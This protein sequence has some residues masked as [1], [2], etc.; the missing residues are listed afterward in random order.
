MR[1]A[2]SL[3]HHAM[4]RPFLIFKVLLTMSV[5]TLALSGCSN[6]LNKYFPEKDL[7]E[8]EGPPQLMAEGQKQF[9]R[10]YWEEAITSFETVKDRY[11][12]SKEA[13]IAELKMADALYEKTE[14]EDAYTAYNEF[15]RLHPKNK[16]IP[17]VIYQKGMC[18]FQRIT[19]IDREQETT[20]RAK[21]E[22]ERLINRFPRD[23]YAA[24]ARKNIRKCLI[25]L[26][27]H[28]LYVANFYYRMKKY[29]A[30]KERYSYIIENYPDMG[31]YHDALEY[32]QKC[33]KRIAAKEQ[34]LKE[35]KLSQGKKKKK[36][37]FF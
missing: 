10:G 35:E 16:N 24:K 15:E 22:F 23:T 34:D 30:A 29:K 6:L 32:I 20:I 17:Y 33:N 3:R 7:Q 28:E 12:Y 19:T 26:A 31:Q 36:W 2:F 4:Q 21:D 37:I 9:E 5:A 27:E 8:Q 13:I 1:E 25:Y 11:P 18:Y 14:Y